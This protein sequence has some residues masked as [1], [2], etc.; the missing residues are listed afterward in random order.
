VRSLSRR[1]GETTPLQLGCAVRC[2]DGTVG[3]L[4]DVVIEPHELRLT[5]LVVEEPDGPARLVPSQLLRQKRT[6]KLTVMLS[7]TRAEVLACESI[8]SFVY[9]GIDGFP[10][11]DE[12]SD[13]GIEETIVVPSFGATEFGGYAGDPEEGYGVTYDRIPSGSAELRRASPVLSADG[14]EIGHVDGFLLAG[15]RVTHVVLQSGHRWRTRPLAIPVETVESIET[16]RVA[17]RLSR[18]TVDSFRSSHSRRRPLG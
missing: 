17:L 14:H 12:R 16:D 2:T 11:S 3:R 9:V 15:G 8:R 1:P 10:E 6:R 7:C 13:V 4:A 5:H 18:E